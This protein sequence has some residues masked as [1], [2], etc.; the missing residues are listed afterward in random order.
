MLLCRGM[1]LAA[2]M[3]S[4]TLTCG[5][6]HSRR[7]TSG[8]AAPGAHRRGN[9]E[10]TDKHAAARRAEDNINGASKWFEPNAKHSQETAETADRPVAQMGTGTGYAASTTGV[11][12]QSLPSG[13]SSSVVM[14]QPHGVIDQG[15]NSSSGTGAGSKSGVVE[16]A[17]GRIVLSVLVACCMIAAILWLPRRL[18]PR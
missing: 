13:A 15:G 17:S 5:C 4:L 8:P 1:N 12:P 16:E 6:A 18:N 9:A 10:L 14:T 3:L 11:V 2:A 7:T